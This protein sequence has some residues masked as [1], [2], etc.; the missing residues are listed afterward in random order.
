M[1]YS[2]KER[3]TA[4]LAMEMLSGKPKQGG[5]LSVGLNIV[6]MLLQNTC[7]SIEDRN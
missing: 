1:I 7:L 3:H 5:N 6:P 2:T 4:P